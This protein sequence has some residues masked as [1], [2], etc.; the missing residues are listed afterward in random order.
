MELRYSVQGV[1]YP[2][3]VD[4]RLLSPS[5]LELPC[6]PDANSPSADLTNR[7]SGQDIAIVADTRIEGLKNSKS[8]KD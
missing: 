8:N 5:T 4:S 7:Q 1:L 3:S 6:G 2:D